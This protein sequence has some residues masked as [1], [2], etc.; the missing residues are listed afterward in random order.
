[1]TGKNSYRGYGLGRLFGRLGVMGLGRVLELGRYGIIELCG[2]GILG[3]RLEGGMDYILFVCIKYKFYSE[4]ELWG[5][6]EVV[7]Y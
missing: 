6:R 1:M 3:K 7:G 2:Y 5:Y 4:R